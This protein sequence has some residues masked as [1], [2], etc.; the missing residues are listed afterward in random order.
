MITA[1]DNKILLL[2]VGVAE[3]DTAGKYFG[4]ETEAY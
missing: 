4:F 3:D 2:Y 1:M